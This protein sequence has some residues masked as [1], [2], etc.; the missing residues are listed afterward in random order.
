MTGTGGPAWKRGP[1]G[2]DDDERDHERLPDTAAVPDVD[3][4]RGSEC[5]ARG[6][7]ARANAPP[8]AADERA[9]PSTPLL[10]LPWH[11]LSW[12]A[13]G[14]EARGDDAAWR[15]RFRAMLCC[16]APV[17]AA[18]QL[19][20]RAAVGAAAG[21]AP[22]PGAP[23]L[24]PPPAAAADEV[25]A[26][27][28]LRAGRAS[29]CGSSDGGTGG[30]PASSRSASARSSLAGSEP[31][32]LLARRGSDAA[33]GCAPMARDG[34]HAPPTV[35]LAAVAAAARAAAA[36][37]AAG[38]APPPPADD[39][40][41]IASA[42]P[43]P[44]RAAGWP[45][46]APPPLPLHAWPPPP[47]PPA[48][49]GAAPLIGPK[50]PEDAGK[51]T[52]VLD[53]DE[54]LVHSSFRPVGRRPDYIVPVEIDGRMVDI[55][56]LKRPWVDHFLAVLGERFEVRAGAR[57]RAEQRPARSAPLITPPPLPRPH[58]GRRVHRVPRQV[59]R[60]ATGHDGP[61]QHHTLAAVPRGVHAL[62]G[63]ARRGRRGAAA[64][65][66][67]RRMAPAWR[68]PAGA[69]PGA[70]RRLCPGPACAA[71]PSSPQLPVLT[72]ATSHSH[73][74]PTPGQPGEGPEPAGAG[75]GRHHHS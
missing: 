51:K 67:T 11:A 37:A 4:P 25:A 48:E 63:A 50:R 65:G 40:S 38:G 26:N 75:P 28:P 55:Y 21:G 9:S 41:V 6:P 14:D 60:P 27:G 72:P 36:V 30:S 49:P 33:P 3:G 19:A 1:G 44:P 35:S 39:G 20:A 23:L 64:G 54:T 70:T 32:A 47:A 15:A 42:A 62:P 34:A 24:P 12:V 10:S 52:L 7:F 43:P 18:L 71:G 16:F 13:G 8:H 31:G 69:A 66:S 61:H 29:L 46:A 73:T 45:A 17:P 5:G 56:V 22:P 58:P 68:A 74:P 2:P 53:L 59:R 57:R